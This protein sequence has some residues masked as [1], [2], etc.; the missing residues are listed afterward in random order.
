MRKNVTIFFCKIWNPEKNDLLHMYYILGE[1]KCE[2]RRCFITILF[3]FRRLFELVE[4]EKM[5]WTID[6]L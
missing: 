4:V 6:W 2:N 1:C 5:R 3:P